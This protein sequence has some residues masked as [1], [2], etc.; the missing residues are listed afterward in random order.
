MQVIQLVLAEVGT[1]RRE[2]W[3]PRP[4]ERQEVL[5]IKQV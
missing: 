4:L 5:D 1:Q 2:G 3:L